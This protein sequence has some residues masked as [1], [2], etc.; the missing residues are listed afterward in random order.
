MGQRHRRR[1][2]AANQ[3]SIPLSIQVHTRLME[4][5]KVSGSAVPISEVDL[6]GDFDPEAWDKKM[7]EMFNDEY[8]DQ[9]RMP[10]ETS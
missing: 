4:I 9:V 7:A 3:P 8:Y 6:T 1:H 5:Q 10:H 2:C